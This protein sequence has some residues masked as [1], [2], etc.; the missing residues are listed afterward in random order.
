MIDKMKKYIKYNQLFIK[1]SL[2]AALCIIVVTILVSWF[3]MSL[4]EDVYIEAYNDSNQK[5]ITQIRDDY[6]DLHTDI[7]NV[8][9]TCQNSS[10]LK[11]YLTKTDLSS[12]EESQIIYKMQSSFNQ[13][14]I[15]HNNIASNILMVGFNGKTSFPSDLFGVDRYEDIINDKVVKKALDNPNQVMYQYSKDGFCETLKGDD[16]IVAIKVLRDGRSKE[17]YGLAIIMI[18]QRDFASYYDSL[19]DSRTNNVH[20]IDA[21]GQIVS[22]NQNDMIGETNA[23]YMN[24]L[25]KNKVSVMNETKLQNHHYSLNIQSMPFMDFQIL[26]M[27]DETLL[28]RQI[29]FMPSVFT[30][31]LFVLGIFI[32]IMIYLMRKS[33]S[34]LNV[35]IKQIPA[36][37]EGDFTQFIE[38]KGSGEIEELSHAF[39]YMMEGLQDYVSRVVKLQEEKR[40]IE[41]H[42]LQMQINPHFVYNTLTS[43]KFLVW[44]NKNDLAIEAIEAF[45]QLLRNTLSHENEHVTIEEEM[46]NVQNYIK[47]QNIRYNNKINTTYHIDDSCKDLMILKML[48]QPFVENSIFHAF[49]EQDV[50]MLKVFVRVIKDQLV[51]E[52]IDNGEGM[53]EDKVIKLLN[54]EN[55]K[56]RNFSGI[57]VNNVNKRI[58]LLYGEDYGVNIS[59]MEGKGTIVSIVLP[60]L[61]KD[62]LSSI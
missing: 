23:D 61:I 56:R 43:I 34:P 53:S 22:S 40:L 25:D 42:A 44:Q 16:V 8:L 21:N 36:I 6:Y 4:S 18:E 10:A 49:N 52:I 17:A 26:S 24:I 46:L 13:S 48:L 29:N 57:G 20:L 60:I 3:V 11:D 47:I 55:D 50:G 37:S 59:S 33:L 27:V 5:I 54:G 28:M 2:I 41:I 30:M 15:L 7:I 1:I 9:T 12:S 39:N 62:E 45:I 14:G 51:I 35:M 58:K 19:I 32:F 31:A 38:V